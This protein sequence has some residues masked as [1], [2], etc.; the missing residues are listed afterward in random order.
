M[1]GRSEN[2]AFEIALRFTVE[3]SKKENE[4][5]KEKNENKNKRKERM[6]GIEEGK[7]T[8]KR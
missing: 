2:F 6:I 1:V 5:I 4:K 3:L 7:R 8:E